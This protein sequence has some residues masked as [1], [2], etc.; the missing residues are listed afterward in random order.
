MKLIK[1]LT[2]AALAVALLFQTPIMRAAPFG[3]VFTYQGRLNFTG[4][5]SANGFY[6]FIFTLHDEATF[7]SPVGSAVTTNAV[8]VTNGLFTVPLDFGALAFTSGQAR[9][10]QLQVNTNGITPLVTLNPRQRITPTPQ[11]LYAGSATTATTAAT[12]S[13][14]AAGAVG[15]A[16]IADGSITGADLNSSLLNNTFWKLTGNDVAPGQFLGSTNNQPVEIRVNGFRALRLEPRGVDGP[17]SLVGG[18]RQNIVNGQGA[19]IAGG[20][21]SGAHNQTDGPYAF[22]G[23]GIGGRA[24][25]SAFVGAGAYNSALGSVS[26][27]GS[28]IANTN[29]GDFAAIVAGSNNFVAATAEAAFIGGGTGHRALGAYSTISGGLS[30][31]A[32]GNTS[33]AA[34]NR[35]KANHNGSFVWADSQPADFASLA[36]NQF[37]IR[38]AG[39]VGIN[40]PNPAATLDVNGGVRA[41]GGAPGAFGVN[42]NG[43]AFSGNGGDD[44]GGMFSSANGQVEFYGNSLERMRI[45]ETGNVGIGTT[46]PASALHVNGTVTATSF[47]GSGAGLTSLNGSQLT[48]GSVGGT[49]IT[50]GTITAADVNAPS[51]NTT[52]WRSGGNAVGATPG[53]NSI[54]TT[55]NQPL[56]VKVNGV[57]ALRIDPTATV[58]NIV[59]GL[60]GFRPT[61]IG[62]GVRGA[63]VAGGNAPAGPVNGVGAGDFHA[64]FDSDGVIGGGFGNK[65][66]TDDGNAENAPFATVSGGVFNSAANYAA[67]VAGGDGNVASG[68]RSSVGGGTANQATGSGATIGGGQANLAA[69]THAAVAGG[70]WNTASGV[71]SFI[72]GGGGD[73]SGGPW[74]NTASG[75]WSA[76]LGGWNNI[77]SGYSSVVGGG[78]QNTASGSHSVVPGGGVNTAAGNHSFAAGLGAKANH[79][80]SFVWADESGP[81][82]ASTGNNQF[83]IRARGGIQIDPLTSQFF[84]SQTRQFINVYGAQY[85]IGVQ[86]DTLYFRC[87]TTP[88]G[89]FIWYKGGVHDG[90]YSNPGG[91]TELMHLVDDKLY[92]QGS[93]VVD[94]AG[95][96]NGSVYSKSLTFGTSSGE[97]IASRRIGS[98]GGN[99]YGLDFYTGGLNRMTILND[100]RVGI[101]T[102]SPATDL[103]VIGNI[104]ASGNV[105]ATL[106]LPCSDRNMKENFSPIDSREV[107]AKVVSLPISRWNFKEA[108]D[109]A[110]I[111]PM[112]QDFHAAFAVGPDDKHI[113]TVDADGV[114]LAAIQGLNQKV[115][116]ENATLRAENAEL[117]QRLE[118]LEQLM[119]R[120]NGGAR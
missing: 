109:T 7:G 32:A 63:V 107:L 31:Q 85:G 105:C 22:I 33:F 3:S 17:P 49:A 13:S 94:Q 65:V 93:V 30:N 57:T 66:G 79:D 84:G 51:F 69:N 61:V 19:T 46:A 52:F 41:R 43:Y 56:V 87:D 70:G 90:G 16:A 34:G 68:L 88:N 25:D 62:S 45:T 29:R 97:G 37:L 50:D 21:T 102:T 12:A 42:N 64:V 47:S 36:D 112:A 120:E 118:K 92:V 15:G 72:G 23:A 91:G 100:G 73:T 27:V 39:N 115:D 71:S 5:P 38:A 11:A 24:G 98:P 104:M 40:K 77:A 81:D 113:G 1:N 117:K 18:Y 99:Q 96:N 106:F 114:A 59:G 110:H 53:V 44:D 58:P 48:S 9:Y 26:M 101:G 8:P 35:A 67:S 82:F 83:C 95:L 14:V 75:D 76:I 116:S 108:K 103:H 119:N 78:A 54:G 89:G 6:D 86:S 20:G 10:L 55:D 74:P 4:S 28:G 111:G 80:G 2:F 60:A